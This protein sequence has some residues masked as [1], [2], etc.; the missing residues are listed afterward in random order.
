M[1]C[2]CLRGALLMHSARMLKNLATIRNDLGLSQAMV[3]E[4]SGLSRQHIS[5]IELGEH[6]PRP[7]TMH[8]LAAVYDMTVGAI[9]LAA[10]AT[11]DVSKK[12]GKA[13][14]GKPA[15]GLASV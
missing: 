13:Q 1:L 12:S 2:Y 3:A 14:Q 6:Y 5:V 9:V 7:Q 8:K 4:R 11:A 10:R 15:D